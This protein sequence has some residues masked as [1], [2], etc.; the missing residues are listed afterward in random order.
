MDHFENIKELQQHE[1]AG[2]TGGSQIGY[3]L[4]YALGYAGKGLRMPG[5]VNIAMDLMMK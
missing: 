3:W 1:L 2:I 5:A 4:G